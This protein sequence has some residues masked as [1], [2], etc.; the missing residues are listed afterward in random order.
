MPLG[1]GLSQPLT[2][3]GRRRAWKAALPTHCLSPQYGQKKRRYLP[4]N[5]QHLYFFLSECPFVR[6]G[7][8]DGLG[9]EPC[10]SL[11][12]L[13]MP[14]DTGQL[15]AAPWGRGKLAD[16]PSASKPPCKPLPASALVAHLQPVL[17][18]TTRPLPGL[19]PLPGVPPAKALPRACGI[20]SCPHSRGRPE[21]RVFGQ[22]LGE[23]GEGSRVGMGKAAHDLQEG[24]DG[25]GGEMRAT[26]GRGS[27]AKERM[28]ARPCG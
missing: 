17:T 19:L 2:L 12:W 13:P 15:P 4:Y 18:P 26:V 24:H 22:L 1:L 9:L 8:G 14:A 5:H 20:S 27:D 25:G 6:E 23:N 28:W 11:R 7:A 21:P 3:P 16:P 10:L